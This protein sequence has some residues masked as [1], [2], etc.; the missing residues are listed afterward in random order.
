MT[1]IG[2]VIESAECLQSVP[3]QVIDLGISQRSVAN[4]HITQVEQFN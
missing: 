4:G 1:A 2:G 3:R